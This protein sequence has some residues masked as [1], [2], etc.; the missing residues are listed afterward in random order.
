V[1][2]HKYKHAENFFLEKYFFL[3]KNQVMT[4]TATWGGKRANQHGRPK[5]PTELR[6]VMV[7]AMVNPQTKKYLLT[8]NDNLGR[9]IDEIV[10]REKNK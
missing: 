9:A 3:Y 10:V 7:T 2:C 5:L 1:D 4:T 8:K 6:R